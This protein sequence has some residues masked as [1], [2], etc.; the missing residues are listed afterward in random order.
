MDSRPAR[1]ANVE[2]VPLT[3]VGLF[4]CG[5]RLASNRKLRCVASGFGL[6]LLPLLFRAT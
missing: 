6:Q 2:H 4:D 3:D 1:A 5:A